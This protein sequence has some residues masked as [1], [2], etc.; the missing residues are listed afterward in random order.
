MVATAIIGSAII[1]GVS[2]AV[3]ANSAAKAQTKAAE[4]ASK[5]QLDMFGQAKQV[6]QPYTN[7]GTTGINRLI[8]LLPGLTTPVSMTQEDLEAT[9][10]YKFTLA[11]G[12][13]AVQNSAAARGLG[14]SGAAI[15]GGA[16]Y[17]TGLS[18]STYNT[19]FEQELANRQKILD[20]LSASINPGVQ[21]GSA[22]AGDAIT[23]GTN[24][25][26]NQIGAGN[27][28]A[29]AA[30]ATGN[31]I[32]SIGNSLVAGLTAKNAIPVPGAGTSAGS[33]YGAVPGLPW[34][35]GG[36]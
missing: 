7:A 12:L 15:K 23:T 26:S 13:K 4:A 21:A 2:S 25:G 16:E 31:A 30:I 14:S 35:Q 24:V 27:A 9:P 22:L 5:T 33:V 34:S 32:G 18:D 10:G 3:G 11:Q 29:G 19:R 36:R 8:E 6:L 17:A 28:K 1:G 20:A